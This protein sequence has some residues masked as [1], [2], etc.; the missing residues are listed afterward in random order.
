MLRPGVRRSLLIG[1][2]I[3]VALFFLV[4]S[5][6]AQ[7]GGGVVKVGT[8]AP[9]G[10]A[11][12]KILVAMGA[13]WAQ[14][15]GGPTLRIYPGGI[16]GGEADMV[17]KMKIGQID[18]ALITANGLAQ[19]DRSV[20]ALQSIPM[21]YRSLDEV[22]LVT[23]KIRPKLD[24]LLREEGF[25]VL[26]WGDLGWVHIFSKT[27]VT[28]PD[29]LRKLKLFTWAGDTQAFDLY[30]SFGF[31]PVAL[32]TADILPMLRTGMISAVAQPPAYALSAQS[33]SV[34]NHML[35]LD[36][37]PLVGALVITERAWNRFP[38]A[39]QAALAQAAGEAGLQMKKENRAAS[40]AAIAAMEKRGLRVTRP[41]DEVAAQWRK[42]A[43][44]AYP[45]I[46]GELIPADYFDEVRRILA[47]S[48]A[49]RPAGR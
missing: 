1:A 19:I 45:R 27:P 33:F 5:L 15:P 40:T 25:V 22:D 44:S 37:A 16:T 29:D 28:T 41:G 21:L 10:S 46:R 31:Q 23:Q 9:N 6:A 35:Q 3:T 42:L 24:R 4:P 38:P 11:L 47:E 13:R 26:F 36:W 32:E 39:T 8:L 18:A 48:R 14:T 20:E 12:H 43:E 17:M 49:A 34:A 30:K 7:S 2:F